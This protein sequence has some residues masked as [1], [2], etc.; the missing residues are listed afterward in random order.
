LPS[1]NQL[2]L[3]GFKNSLRRTIFLFSMAEAHFRAGM[4]D[5]AQQTCKILTGL[6]IGRHHWG[7]LYVKAFYMRGQIYEEQEKM[8]DA[9]A[10]YRKFLE[11]WKDADPD[12]PVLSDARTRL[13]HLAN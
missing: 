1:Q 10:H 5:K 4:M 7:E 12:I 3:A 6:T 9:V 11:L 2:D 8:K 13:N